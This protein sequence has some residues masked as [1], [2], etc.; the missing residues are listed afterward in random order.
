M[1]NESFSKTELGE[2]IRNSAIRRKLSY[3]NIRYFFAIYLS[4]H[5]TYPLAEFHYDFFKIAENIK[6]LFAVILA[7]RGSGKS[8]IF[9]LCYPIWAITGKQKKRFVL[10]ITQTQQQAKK[11]MDNIKREMETNEVLKADIGPFI[12]DS[13]EWAATSI[14]LSKYDARIMTVSAE[15]GIRGI[16]HGSYRPDLILLDDIEDL[17]NVKTQEGRDK[18]FDWFTGVIRPLGDLNTK[19]LIIGTRL[20]ED[21]LISRIILAIKEKRMS[22]VYKRY[23]IV[24]RRGRIAWKG[25]YPNKQSIEEEKR[26]TVNNISWHREY[27]LEL[28]SSEE[29]IVKDA[30]IQYYDEM[31]HLSLLRYII[32]GVDLAISQSQTSDYTSMV[33]LY[34]F[35]KGSSLRIYVGKIMVNKRLTLH[36]TVLTAKQLQYSISGGQSIT[37]VVEDIGYQQSAIEFMKTEG[38]KAEGVKLHGQDKYTRLSMTTPYF[39]QGKIFFPKKG[40]ELLISQLKGFPFEKHDD[41]VDAFVYGVLKVQE[42]ENRPKFDFEFI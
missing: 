27:L 36:Q 17:Q 12:E 4:E 8:T 21:D 39:E 26:K 35:G 42:E 10:I 30:W 31:P 9:S 28:I 24:D 37:F 19:T 34:V 16:R 5:I 13:N 22:G 38:I 1:K 14:I 41:A 3:E 15:Q 23:P 33:A 18:L 6:I 40:A 7:F 29:Q 32:V 2:I 20:H 11:I 25:K